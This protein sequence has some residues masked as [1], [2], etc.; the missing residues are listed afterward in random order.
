MPEEI[1]D[2]VAGMLYMMEKVHGISLKRFAFLTVERLQK[3][4]GPFTESEIRV[5]SEF[6]FEMFLKTR[7]IRADEFQTKNDF[8]PD[9]F[10]EA[11]P[12]HSSLGNKFQNI[13]E[14]LASME[15]R[16]KVLH[17]DLHS[18]NL[19]IDEKTETLYLIDFGIAITPYSQS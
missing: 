4:L 5:L 12:P 11:F 6:E 3:K 17:T 1:P 7:K 10:F 9:L 18:D 2:S 8:V 14:I 19:L 13:K 16:E 15:A